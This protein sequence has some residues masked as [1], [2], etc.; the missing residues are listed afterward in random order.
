VIARIAA[1]DCLIR[2]AAVAATSFGAFG[3]TGFP[4]KRDR[5]H[6]STLHREKCSRRA[7]TKTGLSALS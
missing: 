1:L 3:R 5:G 2:V 6:I 7:E 4:E